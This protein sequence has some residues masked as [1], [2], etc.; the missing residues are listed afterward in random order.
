MPHCAHRFVRGLLYWFW[1]PYARRTVTVVARAALRLACHCHAPVRLRL[2]HG[3]AAALY[4]GRLLLPWVTL[5]CV[6][7]PY[8]LYGST[9]TARLCVRLAV[10]L[11]AILFYLTVVGSLLPVGLPQHLLVRFLL[12]PTLPLRARLVAPLPRPFACPNTTLFPVPHVPHYRFPLLP[13]FVWLRLF[14]QLLPAVYSLL[15]PVGLFA[16]TRTGSASYRFYRIHTRCRCAG[17]CCSS[18]LTLTTPQ[19]LPVG[20]GCR[21]P[22]R[23]G[24]LPV[25]AFTGHAH[26]LRARWTIHTFPH[27]RA[28]T[29]YGSRFTRVRIAFAGSATLPLRLR[30]S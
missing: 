24:S 11:T 9:L 26:G 5:T 20:F 3:Y 15:V 14:A 28:R 6:C 8:Y 13:T 21:C 12:L 10:C 16:F 18:R 29:V 22:L 7:L 17:S 23:H 4:C 1:L 2:P 25:A 27:A 19:R 30:P